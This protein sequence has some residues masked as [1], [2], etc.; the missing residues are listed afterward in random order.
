MMIQQLDIKINKYGLMSRGAFHPRTGDGVP[1]KTATLVMIG[2]AGPD[3][4]RIFSKTG[5]HGPDPLDTWTRAVLDPIAAS[6][7][8]QAV[9]PFDGP[10]HY[11]FQRWAMRADDVSPSPIGP[12]VH[13]VYGMWHAYRAAFL[14]PTRLELPE[15]TRTPSPCDS[16]DSKPCLNT[17]PVSAFTPG[18]YDV[19]ACRTHIASDAGRDCLENACLAR[20]ACPV[21]QDYIY[22]TPQASF[23]MHHFLNALGNAG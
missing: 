23:H 12:L 1:E 14:F 13:P 18:H 16:C 8:A 3:M 21:G 15:F 7:D 6:L 2:N 5:A 20:R 10:P 19:P 11:P 17:C 22:E 4:W 9:Y